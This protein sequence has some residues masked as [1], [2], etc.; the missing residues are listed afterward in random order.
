M[1]WLVELFT[2][3]IDWMNSGINFYAISLL[4]FTLLIR[5]LVFPLDI[6]SRKGMRKM[7]K[8]QPKINELQRK[9]ANDQAKLQ[10]KQQEL[11]R[12][13]H[14]NPL[15]GCLP[16]LLQ[17]P[18]LILMFY[19]MRSVANREMARQVLQAIGGNE[20]PV[21]TSE[22]FIW[23]K[24]IWSA[25]SLFASIAPAANS[26]GQIDGNTWISAFTKL[27]NNPE[28]YGLKM[29]DCISI[30]QSLINSAPSYIPSN[31]PA[32]ALTQES[33]GQLIAS[34]VLNQDQLVEIG[35]LNQGQLVEIFGEVAKWPLVESFTEVQVEAIRNLVP[36]QGYQIAQNASAE[37]L[38]DL[39]TQFVNKDIKEIGGIMEQ[40][41]CLCACSGVSSDIAKS[42]IYK[43]YIGTDFCKTSAEAVT[44]VP[45]F[46]TL[47]KNANGFIILAT[48]SLFSQLLM[49]KINPASPQEQ[50]AA[51]A[52]KDPK[53]QQNA[54]MTKFMKYFFP[55]FSF[56]CCI[57]SYAAFAL[58]WVFSNII[59]IAL[60]FVINKYLDKQEAKE[61][62]SQTTIAGEGKIR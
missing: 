38:I 53:Q 20:Y 26:L 31:A 61:G 15:S 57:S 12:E 25:D 19:A 27:V 54:G 6:K 45:I 16:M 33:F 46:G 23:V 17:Y 48:M 51:V 34:G 18:I 43:L 9:Y 56:Y 8:I 42:A 2:K 44:T 29:E 10:R 47:Y 3:V 55:I 37:T 49:T 58:Y 52:S 7:A 36:L 4:L 28:M 11:M 62:N 60:T 32:F 39:F 40:Q 21:L 22:T 41:N 14:Y 50:Q 59:M 1:N 13:E 24:N 5:L 30:M 35:V